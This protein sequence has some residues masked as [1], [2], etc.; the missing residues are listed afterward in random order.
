M[1]FSP[2]FPT[3]GALTVAVHASPR[4]PGPVA[5]VLYLITD[6]TPNEVVALPVSH[7]GVVSE[8]TVTATGGDGGVYDVSNGVPVP[9]D[10]LASQDSI[11]RTGNVSY[12]LDVPAAV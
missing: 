8:G 12:P 9:L 3:L 10:A 4:A 6:L 7:D 11:V 5:K 2:L 1:R